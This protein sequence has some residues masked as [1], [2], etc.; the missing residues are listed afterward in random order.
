MINQKEMNNIYDNEQFFEQ[1][2]Q[3]SRS[4]QG[5]SGAG[6]WH[7][8]KDMFPD[9]K[10]KQVLDLGCGYGWHCKYAVECGA[11]QVL[12]IDLSEKMIQEAQGK[13][14]DPKIQY[15]VCGLETYG[16]PADSF[17]CVI[18]NLVLHYVRDLYEIYGRVYRT[19]K[20]DGVFLVNIEH[21]AFTAGINEDW[22]Y[23]KNGNPTCW[24]IDNYFYPGERTT[25]FLGQH[26]VK[27]HHTLEQI[28]M[29][30]LNAG[31]Q[32][33]AVK[34]AYPSEDMMEIPG[35]KD[36][37]RRPMMLLIKAVK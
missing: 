15:E 22:E 19:L 31:F 5:L 23:D 16:Y 12:G 10:G 35:M 28:L 29:G 24:P 18:S 37:M 8:F 17:D 25:H 2:A 6:E 32:L 13:N 26:V 33:E 11:S 34:E 3:M 36:E 21:P 27:Q 14:A 4:R 30:L 20:E 1:Y 7:Q 9:L